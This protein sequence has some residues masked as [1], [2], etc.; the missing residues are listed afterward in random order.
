M[1]YATQSTYLASKAHQ[2][3]RKEKKSTKPSETKPNEGMTIEEMFVRFA[4]NEGVN[5]TVRTPIYSPEPNHNDTDFEKLKDSDL[6][7]KEE[8][9]KT[10][11]DHMAKLDKRDKAKAKK[12]QEDAEAAEAARIEKYLAEKEKKKG[13]D[14]PPVPPAA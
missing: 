8:Y 5:T 7:D 1:T 12:D 10:L 9:A 6:V 14:K 3:R 13:G 11:G 4:R 2:T